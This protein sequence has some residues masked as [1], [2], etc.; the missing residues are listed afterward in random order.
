MARFMLGSRNLKRSNSGRRYTR[1]AMSQP[2]PLERARRLLLE[3]M[4]AR[5][6]AYEQLARSLGGSVGDVEARLTG[7]RPL[8]LEWLDAALAVLAVDPAE[9]FRRLYQTPAPDP[10][11]DLSSQPRE[12]SSDPEEEMLTREEVEALVEEVR[13]LIRGS[14]RIIEAR[15]QAGEERD[16]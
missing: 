13:A 7:E 6:V 2:S 14:S 4:E 15:R 12:D 11:E 8:D 16:G 5:G 9:F 1:G 10:D 3:Y